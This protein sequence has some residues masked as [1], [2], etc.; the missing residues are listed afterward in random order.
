MDI[1]GYSWDHMKIEIKLSWT[2]SAA[3][4]I[5]HGEKVKMCKND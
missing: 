4:K 2:S 3:T 1:H 5:K